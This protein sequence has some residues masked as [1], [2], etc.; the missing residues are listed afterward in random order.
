M[1]EGVKFFVDKLSIRY[2]PPYCWKPYWT[3]PSFNY[4]THTSR[5]SI[6]SPRRRPCCAI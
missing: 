2:L 3:L 1:G 5:R 4:N 6:T